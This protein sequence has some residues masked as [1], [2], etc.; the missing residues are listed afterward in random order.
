M[1]PTKKHVADG[2]SIYREAKHKRWCVRIAPRNTPNGKEQRTRFPDSEYDNDSQAAYR[3]AVAWMDER[4]LARTTGGKSSF[5]LSPH[6][7][8]AARKALEKLN[9]AGVNVTLTALAD[10]YLARERPAGGVID[11]A[12]AIAKFKLTKTGVGRSDHYVQRILD[13][14]R[15][16]ARHLAPSKSPKETPHGT[17]LLCNRITTEMCAAWL[18]ETKANLTQNGRRH[19][20]QDL[21]IFFQ[22]LVDKQHLAENQC[23]RLD[24]G[25]GEVGPAKQC[26][27]KSS[28][29]SVRCPAHGAPSP[30]LLRSRRRAIAASISPLR[31]YAG[32]PGTRER[33]TGT[34]PA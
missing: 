29:L 6:E 32:D 15:Q 21:T 33:E 19:Y 5:L 18:H 13:P 3:A 12:T 14:I 20:Q 24:E 11:L 30:S 23:T 8:E 7:Q 22:W 2:I 34:S 31:K 10:Y 27:E 25:R 16:L 4:A 17:G 26:D 28:S 9:R 1:R